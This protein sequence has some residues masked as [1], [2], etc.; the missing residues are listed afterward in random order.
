MSKKPSPPAVPVEISLESF[1]L[2]KAGTNLPSPIFF[3]YFPGSPSMGYR[4]FSWLGWRF[5][6]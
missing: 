1:K 2:L 3:H 4:G 6:P 5:W